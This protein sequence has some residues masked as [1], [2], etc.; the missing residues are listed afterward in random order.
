MCVKTPL[1]VN[2][3]DSVRLHLG[4]AYL[5]FGTSDGLVG[6]LEV[7]QS[8]HAVPKSSGF[9]KHY[10]VQISCVSHADG[11]SEGDGR[12]ITALSW[13]DML[14]GNVIAYLFIQDESRWYLS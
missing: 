6:H 5:A 12:G 2:S 10:D 9:G 14:D 7:E 3:L 13:A 8:L 11:A 4:K 1:F